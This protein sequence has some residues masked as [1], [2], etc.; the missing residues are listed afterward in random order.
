MPWDISRKVVQMAYVVPDLAK[1]CEEFHR[2]YGIGP[3]VGGPE[4][5]AL[6]SHI[7]RGEPMA[8]I[9]IRGV[10]VQSG[11]MNIE[12]LELVSDTDSA[13][14]DMSRTSQGPFLHHVAIYCDDYEVTRDEFSSKGFP[15][16]SSLMTNFG[17]EI[18]YIDARAATG[19]MI[20]LYPENAII[21]AMYQATLTAARTWDGRD[22]I[23]PWDRAMALVSG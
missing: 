15:V 8:P 18:C 3:F 12:L 9:E 10:F 4:V 23:I 1:A 19:H 21:R 7:Y 11:D 14:H 5:G 17:A 6:D 13:F 20:E 16:A 2:L 22:L